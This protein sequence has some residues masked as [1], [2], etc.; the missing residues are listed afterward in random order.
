[1]LYSGLFGSS[2]VSGEFNQQCFE[3]KVEAQIQPFPNP[4]DPTRSLRVIKF[5]SFSSLAAKVIQNNASKKTHIV[6]SNGELTIMVPAEEN[7]PTV[8]PE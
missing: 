3:A 2:L 1:M 4:G 6:P 5:R 8:L 7:L